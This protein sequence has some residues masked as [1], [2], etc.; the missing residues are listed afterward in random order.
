MSLGLVSLATP[1]TW[2]HVR[3]NQ[4]ALKYTLF[5]VRGR[6]GGIEREC[7]S[8]FS[9]IVFEHMDKVA[10]TVA[11]KG[12]DFKLRA[13]YSAETSGMYSTPTVSRY[14]QDTCIVRTP[15]SI[16]I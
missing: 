2:R 1:P 12:L 8:I 11:E 3:R 14:Y 13:G 16:L 5:Q 4:S 7:E 10:S 6:E 9:L 15:C